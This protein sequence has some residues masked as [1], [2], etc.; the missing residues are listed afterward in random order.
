[1]SYNL[2]ISKSLIVNSTMSYEIL[3]LLSIKKEKECKEKQI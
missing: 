2:E 1:M 3:E